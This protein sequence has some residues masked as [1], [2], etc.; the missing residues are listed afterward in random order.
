[1][2]TLDISFSYL[3]ITTHQNEKGEH[4]VVLRITYR[5]QRKDMFTGLYGPKEYWQSETSRFVKA[6]KKSGELN[7]NLD[8]ILRRV[9]SC[10]DL[11]RI[12]GEPFSLDELV[13]KVKGKEKRPELLMEYM[14]EGIKRM[15]K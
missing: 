13:M 7:R 8:L 9:G 12:S 15:K 4:P 14:E 11:L 10:F 1:M 6:Y 5:S 2:E 3:L